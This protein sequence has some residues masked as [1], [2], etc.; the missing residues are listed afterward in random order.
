MFRLLI[1]CLIWLSSVRSETAMNMHMPDGMME[2]K[3]SMEAWMKPKRESYHN[4]CP[5]VY[6]HPISYSPPPQI[7]VKPAI[8][9]VPKP[10][11]TYVKPAPP[12][13]ILKPTPAP[14]IVKPVVQSKVVYPIYQ[15]PMVSYAPIYHKPMYYAPIVQKLMYESPKVYLKK[16]DVQPIVHKP[17]ISYPIQ[18]QHPKVVQVQPQQYSFVKIAQPVH[19]LPAYQSVVKP[20]CP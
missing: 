11:I 2:D 4:P 18:Y 16:Y 6:S 7:F 17:Q 8:Q 3:T 1:P 14:V 20:Y 12:P 9:Y 5:P 15:K 19:P 10:M 13:V